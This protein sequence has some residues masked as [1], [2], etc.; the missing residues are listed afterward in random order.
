MTSPDQQAEFD[1]MIDKVVQAAIQL[2]DV[3]SAREVWDQ[4]IETYD[5]ILRGLDRRLSDIVGDPTQTAAVKALVLE[6]S[7]PPV[8][9]FFTA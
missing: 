4:A 3:H 9:M 8:E 6:G 5:N 1:R 7:M 2:G